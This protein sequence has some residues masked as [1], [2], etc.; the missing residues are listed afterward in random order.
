M[1]NYFSK[2][3]KFLREARNI[4]KSKMG[5]MVGVNQSTISRWETNEIKPSIDNVEEVAKALNIELP[6]LLIKDLSDPNNENIIS[7]TDDDFKKMLKEKGIMDENGNIDDEKLN[8][9][10]KKFEMIDRFSALIGEFNNRNKE[11]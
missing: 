4:S 8:E 2:N 9:F 10:N 5:E 1:G 3:L 11:D 7:K 6:D